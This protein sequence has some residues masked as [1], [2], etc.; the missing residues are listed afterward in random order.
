[1]VTLITLALIAIVLVAIGSFFMWKS[2][3]EY[4]ALIIKKSQD[5]SKYMDFHNRG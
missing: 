1:M 5:Y 3:K 4:E 2:I